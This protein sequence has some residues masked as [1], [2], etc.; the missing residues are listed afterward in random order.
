M[1]KRYSTLS[2]ELDNFYKKHN[3]DPEELGYIGH[4]DVDDYQEE[5]GEELSPEILHFIQELSEL[6]W[7]VTRLVGDTADIQSNNMGR[8]S[9]GV[10][11]AFDVDFKH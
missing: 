5:T 10:L 6:I 7:D 1:I 8:N 4:F 9:K 2:T 11:K 3:I